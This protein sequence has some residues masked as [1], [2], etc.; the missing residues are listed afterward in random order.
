VL[1][2]NS[3]PS[4]SASSTPP[5]RSPSSVAPSATSRSTSAARS[6]A[7][8]SRRCRFLPIFG[9]TGGP[10][11]ETLVPPR[12]DWTAVSRP[13][14]N[15]RPFEYVAPEQA[16]LPAAVARDLVEE[17]AAGEEVVSRPDHAELV[18]AGVCQNDVVLLG[19]LPDV[20][21][22]ATEPQCRLDR[23]ALVLERGTRQVEMQ[24]VRSVLL[25]GGR[26]EPEPD[27]R[28]VTRQQ[29][30]AGLPDDLSAEH[31]GPERR[32]AGSVVGVE[33]HRHQSRGN[34][35]TPVMTQEV[36]RT[37]STD[38]VNASGRRAGHSSRRVQCWSSGASIVPVICALSSETSA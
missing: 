25:R 2:E 5:Y 15:E 16:D 19:E 14:P 29:S 11:H 4:G 6:D 10:P 24:V 36:Q 27:L 37:I 18:A 26:D 38:E 23:V 17:A 32:Q 34:A 33:A 8:T 30:A 12:S 31:A 20:E 22:A 21:V 9:A 35:R 7:A 13:G 28:V 1:T 3:L